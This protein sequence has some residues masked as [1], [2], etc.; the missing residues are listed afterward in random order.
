VTP[1]CLREK[2]GSQG[3]PELLQVRVELPF[4]QPGGIGLTLIHWRFAR[5]ILGI[6][7]IP[8]PL[9]VAI[10]LDNYAIFI[11]INTYILTYFGADK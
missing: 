6:P 1:D 10:V 7:L 2:L 8:A 4:R 3:L 9:R 5:K 11:H